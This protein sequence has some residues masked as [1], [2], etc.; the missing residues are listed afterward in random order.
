MRTRALA[1]AIGSIGLAGLLAA[2][3]GSAASETA[4]TTTTNE[5]AASTPAAGA[6]SAA[7][8][9]PAAAATGSTADISF[10]QLMIPHHQQAVQ[11]ADLAITNAS[12]PDV[13][14]LAEQIKAAQDPEIAMMK[15]WLTGWGVSD[16]MAG[17]DP[18]AP[19]NGDMGGMDM[20][21]M[22]AS[23]MMTQEDMDTLSN[24]TGE[25]FDRMW[26]QMMIAHHQG[27]VAMAQQVLDTT[28][29]PDVQKLAQA[30]VDGQTTEIDTMQQLLAA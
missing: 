29:N 19:A 4:A 6:G 14:K 5:T 1:L 16:Q 23:G 10:A 20:G 25:G 15:S 11:M 8:T 24:A 3:G 26:L 27:A 22:S 2:C 12:S 17:M 21:G 18:S 7:A 28:S 9:T 13:L 30:V